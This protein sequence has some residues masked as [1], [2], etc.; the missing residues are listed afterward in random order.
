MIKAIFFDAVGTLIFLPRS[1]GEHYRAVAARF[2]A[3]IPATDLQH[4][5]RHAWSAAPVRAAIPGPRPEDDKGWWR[6]LVESVLEQT[7]PAEQRADFPRNAYFEAV[8]AHFAQPQVWTLFPDAAEVLGQLAR[9]G[10]RLGVISNFDRRLEAILTGLGVRRFFAE[11]IV[12][13]QCGADK[14]DPQIFRCALQ[15]L[16][17]GPGEAIHA[18]DDRERDGGASALGIPVFHLERPRTTLRD[19]PGWLAQLPTKAQEDLPRGRSGG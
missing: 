14:P 1:V 8:Y 3:D 16:G 11:I 19:L 4:A 5:F 6:A 15:G 9:G 12:S 17:V 10:Y 13:S 18:G 7:L 2:G